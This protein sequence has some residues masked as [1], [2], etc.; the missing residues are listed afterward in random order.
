M[1]RIQ[2]FDGRDGYATRLST[3]SEHDGGYG[4]YRIREGRRG[5]ESHAGA[6]AGYGRGNHRSFMDQ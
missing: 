6:R 4:Q 5:L 1:V 3:G 2:L